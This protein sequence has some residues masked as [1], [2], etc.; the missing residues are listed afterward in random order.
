MDKIVQWNVANI[1]ASAPASET[2]NGPKDREDERNDNTSIGH[3]EGIS[4]GVR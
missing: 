4:Q 2:V 1:E 3:T